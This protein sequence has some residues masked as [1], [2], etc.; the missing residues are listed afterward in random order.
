MVGFNSSLVNLFI[1]SVITQYIIIFLKKYLMEFFN[2]FNSS[3]LGLSPPFNRRR[4][5]TSV[6]HSQRVTA[7][8]NFNL[9]LL[10]LQNLNSIYVINFNKIVIRMG[11]QVDMTFFF[12]VLYIYIK[13]CL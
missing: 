5:E 7:K 8:S 9:L 1:Y 10:L 3:Q 12:F 13:I 11:R 6:T 2:G 4:A